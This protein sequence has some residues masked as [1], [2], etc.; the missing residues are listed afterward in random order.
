MNRGISQLS[1]VALVA[2]A[3]TTFDDT[4]SRGDDQ[5]IGPATK[6]T[7]IQSMDLRALGLTATVQMSRQ[8]S[9]G[10]VAV[11]LVLS[12]IGAVPADQTLTFR[13]TTRPGGEDPP[14]NRLVIDLPVTVSQGSRTTTVT[15]YFP[16]WTIGHSMECAI[17][18]DG[19]LLED[20]LTE[21][22]RSQELQPLQRRLRVPLGIWATIP[23]WNISAAGFARECR[24]DWLFIDKNDTVDLGTVPDLRQII[25]GE[26]DAALFE[27][28]A[29]SVGVPEDPDRSYHAIGQAGLPTD[30]R[31]YLSYDAIVTSAPS[32]HRLSSNRQAIDA[33]RQWVLQ[34]GTAI[35]YNSDDLHQVMKDWR[36]G[37]AP[38]LQI[39]KLLSANWIHRHQSPALDSAKL[40][41]Q[42]I[43]DQ[44]ING[45][46]IGAGLVLTIRSEANQS[47]RPSTASRG[48]PSPLRW[49]R[50]KRMLNERSSTMLRAGADPISGHSRFRDW[51][52]PGVLQPPV[53]SFMGILS[54]FVVLVG[55]VAYRQTTKYGRSHLMFAIAPILAIVT[56]L[57]MLG[58]GVIADGFDT[59]ARVRQLTWVDGTSGDAG[60]RVLSTY[61]AGIRPSAGLRF[62]AKATVF[63]QAE[64]TGVPWKETNQLPP[65]TL[66]RI[67]VTDDAQRFDSSFLP[68]REQRQ[69]IVHAP[70]TQIGAVEFDDRSA[71]DPSADS[72]MPS[73]TSTFQF[74]IR[75]LIVRDPAGLYWT[76]ERLDAGGT[77]TCVRI[78][79]KDASKRLGDLYNQYRPIADANTRDSGNRDMQEGFD[80]LSAIVQGL[81]VQQDL[82]V[83]IFE[84][85]LRSQ[86]QMS[87]EIPLKHFVAV[88]DV[89]PDVLAVE[90]SEIVDSVRYVFGTLR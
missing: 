29:V 62:P 68:S 71:D 48:V 31:G 26:A 2:V 64:P 58:Y 52:I 28:S 70:R 55:P 24:Q 57:A 87:G 14:G 22:P 23:T 83:G 80:A 1:L 89:S 40:N 49:A 86:L 5:I 12:G 50:V 30:W 84:D 88:A 53:Y 10:Y 79:A 54:L 11:R 56:T 67:T 59:Q 19:R 46:S 37:V 25:A 77:E 9:P 82:A 69:F 7:P 32:L 38:N 75:D 3:V 47:D 34:G 45:Q 27:T 36:F 51:T 8:E 33:I 13:F 39:Q 85:W 60:E 15:R 6:A 17:Y 44:D 42:D 20:S 72:Q 35:V 43:N 73:I 61:F 90:G 81:S 4:S 65:S 18:E 41:D 74:A 78:N 76:V 63:R 16:K 66:G 21:L